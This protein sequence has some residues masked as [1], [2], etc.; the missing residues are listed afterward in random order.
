M[1]SKHS[2]PQE[3]D[4]EGGPAPEEVKAEVPESQR[5]VEQARAYLKAAQEVIEVSKPARLC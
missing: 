1:E 3:L 4:F 2:L 5:E